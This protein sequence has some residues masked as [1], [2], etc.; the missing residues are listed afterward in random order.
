MKQKVT[1]LTIISLLLNSGCCSLFLSGQETVSVNSTPE[2]AQVKIGPYKGVTP[3]TVSIPRG[4]DYTIEVKKGEK[5]E[6]LALNRTIEPIYWINILLWPGLIIDLAT[7]KMFK[8]E[9]AEYN[10]SLE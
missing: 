3:Y 2:G 9:P 5:T 6:T 8:Y 4:K 7:G 10:V 1:W